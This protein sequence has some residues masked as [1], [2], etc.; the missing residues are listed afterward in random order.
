[1]SKILLSGVMALVV[2]P[3]T[4]KAAEATAAVNLDN[5]VPY[6]Q[7]LAAWSDRYSNVTL[8]WQDSDVCGPQRFASHV[9]KTRL[10]SARDSFPGGSPE[11]S[12]CC[13]VKR[14]LPA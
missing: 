8:T 7:P 10:K 5:L 4:A 3:C 6:T 9:A 14:E 2:L 12:R 11:A 1:M 13:S